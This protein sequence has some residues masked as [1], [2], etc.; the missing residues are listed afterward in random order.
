MRRAAGAAPT[1]APPV[2]PRRDAARAGSPRR[3]ARRRALARAR[4]TASTSRVP[5]RGAATSRD[6]LRTALAHILVN[7]R[8]PGA[9]ARHALVRALV[10]PRRR[11]DLAALLRLGHDDVARDFLRW[12]APFQ[13]ANGKV[14]CCV[15]ERGADPVPEND[16]HGEFIFAVA[17]LYRYTGDAATARSDVA[18]R[19]RGDRATW[20]RCARA[21]APA[22]NR[23]PSDAPTSA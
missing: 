5:G 16:S 12:Y 4:S 23:A 14:P 18:A 21:S 13:F 17:E 6:T 9:A 8:R 11:A 7:R 10:D 20:R 2:R 1:R 3:E 15:D 19:A 22:T